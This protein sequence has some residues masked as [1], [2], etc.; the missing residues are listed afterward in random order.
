[1]RKRVLWWG[2]F[3]PN[4]SRNRI[5]R[6]LF[7]EMG[8]E[9][10]DFHPRI[11]L[12]ADL[13]ATL[14]Q[15]PLPD[16]VWVPCFRQR[17]LAAASRWADMRCIPLI[18]DPLISAYDKQ[19]DERRKLNP[20][21]LRA[22]RLL[23]W[24]S[25][26][27]QRADMVIADT[28]VHADYFAEMLGAEREKLAIVYVGAEAP[29]FSPQPRI[30][31]KNEEPLEVLFYGSFIP[32]QGPA[33]VIE[34]ARLYQ[35]PPIKWTLIGQG[36]LRKACEGQAAGLDNV[37]FED[38]VPYEMLPAR[39]LKADIL[40]GVFGTTPKA[41]RVIPNKVY[42]ALACGRAVI[43]QPASAYP[44]ALRGMVDSGLIWSDPGNAESL[45]VRVAE[46]AGNPARLSLLGNAAAV[47]SSY[48]FS[49]QIIQSQLK[50]ALALAMPN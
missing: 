24:E 29:L 25:K 4:Y 5:L 9:V 32:L 8:W 44:E 50:Q 6:A 17:D 15:L 43:T 36:P 22:K 18:F 12:L 23:N 49:Q 39:I 35:G 11:S 16:L 19:V 7:V 41:A 13:E 27:F 45:A 20:E 3:D 33:T 21:S 31:G 40:L 38:W 26:L 34:A 48:F 2:R 47:S 46:L 1:M 28:T 30:S 42:Q 14:R 10:V 37:A